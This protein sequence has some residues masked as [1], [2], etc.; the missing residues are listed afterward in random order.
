MAALLLCVA[1]SQINLN[2]TAQDKT[3]DGLGGLSGGGATTRRALDKKCT[4]KTA[5]LLPHSPLA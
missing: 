4:S 5:L 3:F 1:P 2:Y